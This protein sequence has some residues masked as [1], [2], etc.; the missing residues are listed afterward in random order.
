MVADVNVL[1]TPFPVVDA[2]PHFGRVVR[3]LRPSDYG[4]WAAGTLAA[5]AALY[6]LEMADST[7]PRGMKPHPHGRFVHLRHSLR[8]TAFLGFAGGFLLA[9]QNCSLRLWGWKENQL[10]QDRDREELGARAAQGLPLYG[11]TDLPEYIQGVAHR[12]SMWSQVGPGGALFLRVPTLT[13][14]YSE[15]TAQVWRPALVQL[16][17]VGLG[18]PLRGSLSKIRPD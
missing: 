10:E 8:L 9:Y 15:P 17:Q 5:P 3:Y 14:A 7:L 1:R 11:E 12:N 2:D 6:G 13:H 4:L 18:P 16:C